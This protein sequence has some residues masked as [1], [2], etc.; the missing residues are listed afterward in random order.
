[1]SS[2]AITVTEQAT[3]TEI[4]R[5]FIEKPSIAHRSLTSRAIWWGSSHVRISWKQLNAP[6]A[7]SLSIG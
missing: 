1:M 2:P 5:L 4:T 6:S 7:R 3:Y